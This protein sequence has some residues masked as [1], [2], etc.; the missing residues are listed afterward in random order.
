MA[1]DQGGAVFESYLYW[2]IGQ[3]QFIMDTMNYL[4]DLNLYD[5]SIELFDIDNDNV[6]DLFVASDY[7]RS[8]INVGNEFIIDSSL[9]NNLLQNY[10]TFQGFPSNYNF[11]TLISDLDNNSI[12]EIFYNTETA[13]DQQNKLA[14]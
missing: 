5:G 7:A 10:S 13:V 14:I 4:P 8:Y 11:R 6:L 3:G 9:N 1:G 12:K 2:G